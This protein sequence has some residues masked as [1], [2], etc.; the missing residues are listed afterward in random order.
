VQDGV[1]DQRM[2]RRERFEAVYRELYPS[3]CGYVLRPVR[4]PEDAAEVVAETFATLWRRFDASPGEPSC[5]P[6]CS[7]SRGAS[8]RT[9]VA[10]SS[11]AAR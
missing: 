7:A 9:S 3:I 8:S 2:V 11:G 4:E 10:A 5:A 1:M 6:G